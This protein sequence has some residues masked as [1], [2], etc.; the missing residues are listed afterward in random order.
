M[1][2]E[3]VVNTAKTS[4]R[5]ELIWQITAKQLSWLAFKPKKPDVQA[6]GALMDKGKKPAQFVLTWDEKKL[7]LIVR[8]GSNVTS[9]GVQDVAG[10]KDAGKRY[11]MLKEMHAHTEL[12][13]RSKVPPDPKQVGDLRDKVKQLQDQVK[14]LE[15][16]R[17]RIP[18]KYDRMDQGQQEMG[19][20]GWAKTKGFDRFPR[21]LMAV[22]WGRDAKY[23]VDEFVV[24]D[25]PSPVSPKLKPATRKAIL[26][27]Y[28]AGQ[29]PSFDAARKEI[30]V[31]V[32]GFM[33]PPYV[34]YSQAGIDGEIKRVKVELKAEA[35]KLKAFAK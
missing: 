8:V 11:E 6:I 17:K 2:K 9:L 1:A 7:A 5:L 18:Q 29:K 4:D 10:E 15:D 30:L 31:V 24:D 13:P 16:L 32:D 28:A 35:E 26:D 3:E 12:V 14:Q 27:A 34:K 20:G 25:A 23:I 19:F 22:D 21:F 33:M